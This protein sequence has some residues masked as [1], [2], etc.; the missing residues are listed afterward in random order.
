MTEINGIV[1]V[2]FF[3]QKEVVL[4]NL[5][6]DQAQH[7]MSVISRCWM[8]KAIRTN[9]SNNSKSYYS[10]FFD[11]KIDDNFSNASFYKEISE[12]GDHLCN[13]EDTA[14]QKNLPPA[15]KNLSR[16]NTASSHR[17]IRYVTKS[18]NFTEKKFL[19]VSLKC[20]YKSNDKKL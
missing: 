3:F 1:I 15:S 12:S 8:L 7:K 9:L 11:G 18:I 10:S 13:Q 4:G 20:T 5:I 6:L 17:N 2:S 16:S 14:Q 19:P